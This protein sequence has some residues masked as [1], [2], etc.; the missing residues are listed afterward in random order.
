M[1]TFLLRRLAR[2]NQLLHSFCKQRFIEVKHLEQEQT[3]V[4]QKISAFGVKLLYELWQVVLKVFNQGLLIQKPKTSFEVVGQSYCDFW[5][6][7]RVLVYIGKLSVELLG[8][9]SI[10]VGLNR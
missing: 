8:K 10:W 5:L 7:V 9:L 3:E 4:L 1:I 6:W 2:T